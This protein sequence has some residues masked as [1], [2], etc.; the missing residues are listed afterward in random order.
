MIATMLTN[1][2]YAIA[3]V[4]CAL[5]LLLAAAAFALWRHPNWDMLREDLPMFVR[6][7]ILIGVVVAVAS[8]V[9]R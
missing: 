5:A 2:L 7:S 6:I 4:W 9:V 1:F 8:V 3:V